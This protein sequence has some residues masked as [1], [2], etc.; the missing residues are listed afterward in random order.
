MYVLLLH[1]LLRKAGILKTS[2][3]LKSLSKN[4]DESLDER[5]R[6]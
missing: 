1:F 3:L 2:I 5:R 6:M 4:T